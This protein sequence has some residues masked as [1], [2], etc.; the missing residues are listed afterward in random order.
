MDRRSLI[1]GGG[2]LLAASV[3]TKEA[4]ARAKSSPVMPDDTKFMQMAIDQAKDADYPFGAVIVREGRVLSF[5]RNSTKRNSDP[6]AHAEMMAIRAFLD[7]HE[8]EALKETTLYSSGE[9]CAMCMGAIIWCG[10]KRLVFAA[11]IAQLSARI[12]Q[13]DVTARQIADDAAFSDIEISSGLLSGDAMRLFP[14]DKQ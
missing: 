12:G 2:V 14:T 9:P 6:T 7:G 3:L 4:D 5:G 13:I 1:S 11:S 8:P 10:V